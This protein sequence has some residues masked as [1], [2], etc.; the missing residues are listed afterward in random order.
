MFEYQNTPNTLDSRFLE[1]YL[2]TG[3]QAAIFDGGDG[4]ICTECASGGKLNVYGIGKN[5]IATTR[6]GKSYRLIDGDDCVV[7]YNTKIMMPCGDIFADADR[8]TEVET[9]IDFL[10]FW[11]RLSPLISVMDE[12]TKL[13]VEEAYRNI[14]KGIPVTIASKKL[15]DDFGM[16]DGINIENLTQPDFADKI[17]HTSKLYDDILRWHF[18]KYG[19]SVFGTGKLAQESVDEVNSTVSQSLI[20]PLSMLDERKKAIDRVN[21]L[22]G[23]N[24]TVDFSGAWRAEVTRYEEISGEESI[25]NSEDDSEVTEK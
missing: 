22:F 20:M 1:F 16:T 4:I 5:V 12:K 7:L 14:K 6:N 9:S 2:Q 10:I 13:K 23:T 3:G 19:Q 18:T 21:A 17:Q 15:L 11:T 25:D 8:L 24:I